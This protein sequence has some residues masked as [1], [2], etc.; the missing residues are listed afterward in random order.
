M[1]IVKAD[2]VRLQ[3]RVFWYEENEMKHSDYDSI[4]EK[5]K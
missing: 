5:S 2:F 3:R 1:K 4:K